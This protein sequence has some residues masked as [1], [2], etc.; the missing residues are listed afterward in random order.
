[1]S[2]DTI[3]KVALHPFVNESIASLESMTSLKGHAGEP[4]MD[5]VDQ[6]RFKGYA[7]CSDMRGSLDGVVLMHHYSETALALGN[8]VC[9]HMLGENYDY[10]E[11]NEELSRALSEWGNTIVGRATDFLNR[12]NLG[13]EFSAPYCAMTLDDMDRYLAGVKQIITVPI[14]IDGVG[15]YYFNLLIR[16]VNFKGMNK[17]GSAK[18]ERSPK[19]QASGPI[20]NRGAT[21][22]PY[23]STILLVDDSSLVRR[24]IGRFL[25]ELGYGT[26]IEAT[27]GTEAVEIVREHAIDFAFMDV[28]MDQM[29]GDEALRHIRQMRPDL[30][31]V[32]LSSVTDKAMVD[33]CQE[34]GISGFIFK[35]LNRDN[36]PD[37]LLEQ[38]KI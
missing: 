3:F 20:A 14:F 23:E 11:V 38:L 13:F 34:I 26:I 18:V 5:E 24:A 15:R 21:P 25:N 37:I 31:V 10:A 9:N 30:P 28:V 8:E 36:G 32:M 16:N 19:R 4:F 2:V 27:D 1:M 17:D 22:L 7:V 35:P 6:F 12:H 33:G 29:N